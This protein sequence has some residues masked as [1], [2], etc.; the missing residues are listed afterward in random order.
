MKVQRNS[1]P[2][3]TRTGLACRDHEL[4]L[5]VGVDNLTLRRLAADGEIADLVWEAPKSLP[6]NAARPSIVSAHVGRC[7][8]RAPWDHD[9]TAQQ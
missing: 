9:A 2:S 8:S 7:W 1:A 3:G 4:E 5:G 6:L